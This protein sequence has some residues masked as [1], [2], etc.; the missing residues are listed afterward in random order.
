MRLASCLVASVLMAVV[1]HASPVNGENYLRAAGTDTVSGAGRSD[2][3]LPKYT[4]K[5]GIANRVSPEAKV[6]VYKS[7]LI[8][9]PF[10]ITAI[11]IQL[12]SHLLSFFL[13]VQALRMLSAMH[14]HGDSLKFWPPVSTI[15]GILV[16]SMSVE[17]RICDCLFLLLSFFTQLNVAFPVCSYH[18]SF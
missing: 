17:H 12:V 11:I 16:Y 8:E 14:G 7:R 10:S 15:H 6:H 13:P 1:W 2:N 5:S 9:S 3:E 4:S 18:G